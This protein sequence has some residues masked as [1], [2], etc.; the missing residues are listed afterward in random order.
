MKFTRNSTL[1][2]HQQICSNKDSVHDQC[3]EIIED[4]L[5]TIQ[6][7]K[8]DLTVK[9]EEC[10]KLVHNYQLLEKDFD[11]MKSKYDAEFKIS[12]ELKSELAQMKNLYMKIQD[13]YNEYI[14]E[15]N[16]TT[17]NQF[18]K[19]LHILE[20]KYHYAGE[21]KKLEDFSDLKEHMK[22]SH[23]FAHC[24][25]DDD[26]YEDLDTIKKYL[27]KSGKDYSEPEDPNCKFSSIGQYIVREYIGTDQ[28]MS[29]FEESC[30]VYDK[31]YCS[32]KR[33]N[34]IV[35]DWIVKEY[36]KPNPLDQSIFSSNAKIN[37]YFLRQK[38]DIKKGDEEE[39]Y[40]AEDFR[41]KKF[42]ELVVDP[43]IKSFT[44]EINQVYS[45][46]EFHLIENEG[47]FST[48]FVQNIYAYKA[49]AEF[50]LEDIKE[51]NIQEMIVNDLCEKFKMDVK[52]QDKEY[53]N[54]IRLKQIKN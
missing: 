51:Q 36:I 2:R 8:A 38:L 7:L 21:L 31:K 53:R 22:A 16:K 27:N 39:L 49:A 30:P 33:F 15:S 29:K 26:D 17:N 44:D 34:K 46:Y 25:A 11:A 13:E 54:N 4:H 32:I 3:K 40:W 10:T 52:K 24:I 35:E 50:M 1:T 12:E 48:N 9:N 43:C 19:V 41:G 42:I 37:R 20:D 23:D 45:Y 14:K 28:D 18:R 6:N 47:C 5:K